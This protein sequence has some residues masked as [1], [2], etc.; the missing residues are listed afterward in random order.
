[1]SNTYAIVDL[2]NMHSRAKYVAKGNVDDKIGIALSITLAS[3]RKAWNDFNANHVVIC[4]EGRSWRK[5]VYKPYKANRTE[6]KN[7]LTP[8]ER[9]ED[10]LF[11]ASLSEFQEF[12]AEKTNCTILQ[13][14]ELEADD[15]IA[16]WIQAHPNDNHVIVSTDSDF[17]QLIAKNVSQYNGVAE[18]LT[19]HDGVFDAKGRPVID[20]KTKERK[21]A[22]DPEWLLFEKCIRGDKKDNVFSA[23]PGVRKKGSKNKVGLLEAYADKKVKGFAWNNLMLQRWTDHEG[24]EHRVLDDYNRNVM[25]I[26]LSAQPEQIRQTIND[27]INNAPKKAIP[28]V[29]IRLMKFCATWG[30]ESISDQVESYSKVLSSSLPDNK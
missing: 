22:P 21:P 13:H 10:D 27:V 15:L 8:R 23:F 3:I 1:M 14:P 25:L 28:Q 4:S 16:G 9:E 11:W 7:A 5:D 19:K 30:L 12:L 24:K 18:T 20:K 2:A 6:A 26:D 17:A 29:G